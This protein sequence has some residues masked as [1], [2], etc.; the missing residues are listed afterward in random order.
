MHGKGELVNIWMPNMFEAE[1]YELFALVESS[2]IGQS[3][4]CVSG[5]LPTS[6]SS[7]ENGSQ[8]LK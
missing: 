2:D 6:Q 4:S 1:D 7:S 8:R 5:W 3:Q